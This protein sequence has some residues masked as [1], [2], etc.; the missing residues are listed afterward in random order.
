MLEKKILSLM[1]ENLHGNMLMK[2]TYWV[3]CISILRAVV[4]RT[5]PKST[6][7]I[8]NLSVFLALWGSAQVKAACRTL[9]KLTPYSSS[10]KNQILSKKKKKLKNL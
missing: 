9:M 2:L 3:N 4:T 10:E 5:D 8:D 7:K 6:K 1:P